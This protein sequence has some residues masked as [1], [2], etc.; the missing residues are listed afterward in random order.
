MQSDFIREWVGEKEIVK[1]KI[2]DIYVSGFFRKDFK[3]GFYERCMD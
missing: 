1:L 2:E 3:T